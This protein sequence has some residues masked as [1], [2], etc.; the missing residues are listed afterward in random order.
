MSRIWYDTE[1]YE[2]GSTINLISIGMVAEDG[3]E[4]YLINQDLRWTGFT[5]NDFLRDEVAPH[6]PITPYRLGSGFIWDTGHPDF[7]RVMPKCDIAREVEHFILSTPR[8]SLWAYYS[9]YDHVALA[10]LFGRMVDMPKGIPWR[11]NDIAQERE[12]LG[13]P[14]LPKMTSGEHHALADARWNRQADEFLQHYA[15]HGREIPVAK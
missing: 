4:L 10:Q 5:D 7:T 1:F 3:R 15:V 8:P 13:D 14:E 11:T 6:L 9:S 2:D 12:R